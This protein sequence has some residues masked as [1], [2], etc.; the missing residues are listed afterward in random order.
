MLLAVPFL[1]GLVIGKVTGG[2]FANLATTPIR[3]GWLL[4][5]VLIVQVVLFTPL[6]DAAAWDIRYGHGIYL[7]SL[8]LLLA[9]LC[10]NIR[11][12]QW[13][14]VVLTAGAALNLLVIVVNGGAMPVNAHLLSVTHGT[15]MVNQI[16]GH[17]IVSNVFPINSATRLSILGDRFQMVN[18]VYSIG[19]YV[20]GL[21]GLLLVPL[22]MHR[23]LSENVVALRD[24]NHHRAIGAA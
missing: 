17:S 14:I 16:R 6:T 22:E 2:T 12:L 1:A 23:H 20:I 15:N 11:H 10:V 13:P 7:V 3:L 21:G 8:F 18:S 19:D 5:S 9:G 4:F 24:A